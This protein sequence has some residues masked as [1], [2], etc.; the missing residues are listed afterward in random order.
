[1]KQKLLPGQCESLLNTVPD[2]VD[3]VHNFSSKQYN[4]AQGK[5]AKL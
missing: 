1:M 2:K 5:T 4:Y 3:K